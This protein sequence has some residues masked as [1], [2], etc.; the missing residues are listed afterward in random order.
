MT[1]D[2]DLSEMG[3]R[4][5][6]EML[7]KR[8]ES[9]RRVTVANASHLNGLCGGMRRGEVVVEGDVGDYCG[10][11]NSG[12]AIIV[13]GSAGRFLGDNMTSGRI[14]VEGGAGDGAAD[15]CYGG[16]VLIRGSSGDFLGTMN[17]GATVVVAGNVGDHVGTYMTAGDIIVLGDAGEMLGDYVIRGS[18]YIRGSY[19]SLGNNTKIEKMRS[20]D[21]DKLNTVLGGWGISANP[22]SFQKIAPASSKPFY[23][24]KPAVSQRGLVQ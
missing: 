6:N 23:K 17:K 2:I 10:I 24:E 4:E 20:D 5:S 8:L 13:R 11:L 16:S 1:A 21:I 12:G 15:Y 3:L 14:V 7:R 22:R 18:I 9:E 19:K